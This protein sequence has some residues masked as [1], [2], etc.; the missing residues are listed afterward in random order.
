MHYSV[1]LDEV[2]NNLNIKDNGLYVDATVGYAGHSKEIIKRVKTGYLYA[3][4]ADKE[5]IETLNFSMIF[6]LI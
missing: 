6:S 2:I 1:M 4:D 5:A 3:F